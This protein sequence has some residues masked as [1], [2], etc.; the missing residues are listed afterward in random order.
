MLTNTLRPTVL[1]MRDHP[2]HCPAC[3]CFDGE[4]LQLSTEPT[5]ESQY[6]LLG[7]NP[8]QQI[9]AAANRQDRNRVDMIAQP[10]TFSTC[11]VLKKSSQ[12]ASLV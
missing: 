2:S 5:I 3:I 4:S 11:H 8:T 7:A 6:E 9:G 1:D 10:A 12:C